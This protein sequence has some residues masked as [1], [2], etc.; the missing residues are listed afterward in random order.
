MKTLTRQDLEDNLY[1][2][3]ILGTGGGGELSEGFA[4]IDDALAQGKTF[5]LVSLDE[6]PQDALV[7]TPYLLGAISALPADQEKLYERLPRLSERAL[8]LAYRRFEDYL[9]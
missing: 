5:N 3:T 2:A 4:M 1:G 9:G 8:L 7:C 6:A